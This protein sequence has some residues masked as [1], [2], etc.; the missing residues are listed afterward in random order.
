[1]LAPTFSFHSP[2]D[3]QS[4]TGS[5]PLV[6]NTLL[7]IGADIYFHY[8]HG[9]GV[10]S[11]ISRDLLPLKIPMVQLLQ[12]AL[13]SL[14]KPAMEDWH[15]RDLWGTTCNLTMCISVAHCGFCGPPS[16]LWISYLLTW[17]S[18]R[19]FSINHFHRNFHQ[20]LSLQPHSLRWTE[21][22]TEN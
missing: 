1:M 9:F 8:F 5:I 22:R 16:L 6:L 17:F 14:R 7:N 20:D 12:L 10:L 13:Q 15:V 2:S 18:Q 19:H 11:P 4:H 21:T 3:R